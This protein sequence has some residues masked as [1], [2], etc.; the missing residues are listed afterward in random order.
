MFGIHVTAISFFP[1]TPVTI[2]SGVMFGETAL[3]KVRIW[4]ISPSNLRLF[5]LLLE[6]T[7]HQTVV[8]PN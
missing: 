7:D 1:L 4:E 3:L 2:I 8:C 6:F 5:A